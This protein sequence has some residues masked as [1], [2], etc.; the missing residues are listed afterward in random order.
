MN[1]EDAL[2]LLLKLNN[3]PPVTWAIV[4]PR[5]GHDGTNEIMVEATFVDMLLALKDLNQE[6]N[7]HQ[8]RGTAMLDCFFYSLDVHPEDMQRVYAQDWGWSCECVDCVGTTQIDFD[9]SA[10]V[11]DNRLIFIWSFN[12]D[13]VDCLMTCIGDRCH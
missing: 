4:V 5:P 6:L 2:N 13:P 12:P 11:R 7:G 8:G 3:T 1:H 9:L 10:E